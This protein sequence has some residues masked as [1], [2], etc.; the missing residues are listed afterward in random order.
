MDRNAV[1]KLTRSFSALGGLK[2]ILCALLAFVFAGVLAMNDPESDRN[3]VILIIGLLL[4]AVVY[5]FVADYYS[6]TLGRV[7][8]KLRWWDAGVGVCF[9]VIPVFIRPVEEAL[10]WPISTLS[11]M[12][13]I[14][15]LVRYYRL[16]CLRP[17]HLLEAGAILF[18]GLYPI[19]GEPKIDYPI[20]SVL[21]LTIG[22]VMLI[23]SLWEHA[24]ITRLFRAKLQ[25]DAS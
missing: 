15:M 4:C 24:Y 10:H 17:F 22:T 19:T 2:G 7:K 12:V 5:R 14:G 25:T 13:V 8:T 9:G 16:G 3:F 1:E 20:T 11:L 6:K 23:N 18:A 21:A